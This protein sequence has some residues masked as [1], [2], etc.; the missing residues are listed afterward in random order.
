S[1]ICL[2]LGDVAAG[3]TLYG[4]L[5]PSAGRLLGWSVTDLCLGRLALLDGD[6]ERAEAHLR[7]A[8]AFVH[9]AGA[10]VYGPALRALLKS[11]AG[12]PG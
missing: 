2:A 6:R 4:R 8:E 11:L 10:E 9:R 5:A 12:H 1:E 7:A 3:R